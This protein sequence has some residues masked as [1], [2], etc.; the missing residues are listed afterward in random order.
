MHA[1]W[2]FGVCILYRDVVFDLIDA[3]M[4]RRIQRRSVLRLYIAVSATPPSSHRW[5]PFLTLRNLQALYV[6]AP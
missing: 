3:G 4:S 5:S 1:I 2:Q 6:F